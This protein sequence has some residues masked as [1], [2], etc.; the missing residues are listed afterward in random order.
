MSASSWSRRMTSRPTVP[1][2]SSS[3]PARSMWLPQTNRFGATSRRT[4]CQRHVLGQHLVE[5]RARAARQQAEVERGMGLGVE[6]EDQRLVPLQRQRGGQVDRRGRLAHPALLIQHRDPSHRG[7]L[8]GRM[9][10]GRRRL[11]R[12][13]ASAARI[14][15]ER[16]NRRECT[17]RPE[18]KGEVADEL[19]RRTGSTVQVVRTERVRQEA[20]RAKY[21]SWPGPSQTQRTSHPGRTR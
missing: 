6:V 15:S 14:E 4:L 16:P 20:R 21:R 11:G 8:P 17:P 18:C 3:A 5:R 19:A 9:R 12:S 1:S 10:P 2:S 7:S 13:E